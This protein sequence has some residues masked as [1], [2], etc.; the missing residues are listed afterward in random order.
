M[1]ITSGKLFVQVVTSSDFIEIID[2]KN[3]ISDITGDRFI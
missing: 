1:T 3:Y 2:V